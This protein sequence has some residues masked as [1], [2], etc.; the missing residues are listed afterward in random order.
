VF[1][2]FAPTP[3]DAGMI[4]W[5]SSMGTDDGDHGVPMLTAVLIPAYFAGVEG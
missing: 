3:N 2:P 4:A 1:I 5:T